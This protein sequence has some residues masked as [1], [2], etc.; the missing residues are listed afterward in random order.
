MSQAN[1][2]STS[3]A[4][5]VGEFITDLDG[6]MFDRMLSTALSQTAA[7]SVDHDKVGEVTVKFSFKKIPGTAQVHCEHTLKFSSPTADGK[8][9][10]EAKRTTALHVGKYGALSLAPANQMAFLDRKGEPSNA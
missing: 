7:A 3:A 5:D 1:H 9:G 10:E 2:S 6:G 4:T 8:R